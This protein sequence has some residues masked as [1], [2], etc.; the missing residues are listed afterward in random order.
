MITQETISNKINEE[1]INKKSSS[2]ISIASCYS[3]VNPF[4]I[5]IL[6]GDYLR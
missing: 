6:A 1:I 5:N 2:L 3:Y 4:S